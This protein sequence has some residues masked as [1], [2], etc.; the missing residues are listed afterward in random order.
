MSKAKKKSLQEEE[1]RKED[2][3][4]SPSQATPNTF[5]SVAL[6][7]QKKGVF[8]LL[9]LGF[10]IYWLLRRFLLHLHIESTEACSSFE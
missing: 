5:L 4:F 6:H 8:T 1:S 2:R 10:W 3:S 9:Y 7:L